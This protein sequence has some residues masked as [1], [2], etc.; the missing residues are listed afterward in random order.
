MFA[1]A[2]FDLKNFSVCLSI[3][4]YEESD[5]YL[6]IESLLGFASVT[7]RLGICN[8]I[9]HSNMYENVRDGHR[10]ANYDYLVRRAPA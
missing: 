5:V 4:E 10:M 6:V 7:P 2:H 8:S 9:L 3:M 1:L